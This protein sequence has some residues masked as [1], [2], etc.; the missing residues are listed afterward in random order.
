[1][2]EY[3]H[4][5]GPGCT[6]FQFMISLK[7]LSLYI[8]IHIFRE[9]NSLIS[10]NQVF[11]LGPMNS[12]YRPTWEPD[13]WEQ[14]ERKFFKERTWFQGKRGFSLGQMASFWWYSVNGVPATQLLSDSSI[15]C[16][17]VTL[18]GTKNILTKSLGLITPGHVL[19]L[20]LS[21]NKAAV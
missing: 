13:F 17:S 18:V 15:L 6:S 7:I 19:V 21:L 11:I 5:N 14:G 16:A 3:G 8:P 2:G 10:R 12:G 20:P 9:A 1:M 4:F